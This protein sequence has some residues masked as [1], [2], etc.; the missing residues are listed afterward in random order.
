MQNTSN[1]LMIRP[2]NFGF[3]AETAT[4]NAFQI[5]EQSDDVQKK[6]LLE[7]DN[8]VKKLSANKVDVTVVED[9]PVPYTPD[10]IFPN[11][12]ISFH[13]DKICLYPMYA[14]N[15]RLERK[16]TVLDVLKRKFIINKTIDLAHYE[17]ENIFL[18][19]TGSMVLDR[20]NKLA[21][22]CL[23]ERTNAKI[24]DDF[25]KNFDYSPVVFNSYDLKGLP[26]YHTNVVMNVGEQF[27][28][29]CLDTVK[30][31]AEREMLKAKFEQTGK[32][33]IEISYDQMNNFAGNMLQ[34]KNTE[35]K[36]FLVMSQAAF[37]SLNKEQL[38]TINSYNEIIYTD[39]STIEKNGG[40]SAR[41]ML[42]EIF[43]APNK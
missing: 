12:W 17:K 35:G 15:R 36:Q 16:D 19:G 39:L 32:Q 3:N 27:V 42:A 9:T 14:P 24:L 38:E 30:N 23:S 26:I 41:C 40:G 31:N 2:V 25:C 29:I 43:L 33:L 18:E 1:L 7:F 21:Y 22:A 20:K 13:N 6:A 4:N 34:V 5:N 37:N 11:N 10:S 8:F 28:I